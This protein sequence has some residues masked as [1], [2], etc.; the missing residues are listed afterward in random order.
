MARPAVIKKRARFPFPV[1]CL[2]VTAGGHPKPARSMSENQQN[3]NSLPQQKV[4]LLVERV[5][6]MRFETVLSVC[7][8]NTLNIFQL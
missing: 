8:E 1:S 7:F 6:S 4:T 5:L 3:I 2:L